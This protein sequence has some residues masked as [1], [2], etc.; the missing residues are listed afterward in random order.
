MN[1]LEPDSPTF[2]IAIARA[3]NL[4]E[5]ACDCGG[6]EASKKRTQELEGLVRRTLQRNQV[7][8]E[9]RERLIRE[10]A[11]T[12]QQLAISRQERRRLELLRSPSETYIMISGLCFAVFCM[13]YD[14]K[15]YISNSLQAYFY[16]NETNG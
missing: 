4:E 1:N 5:P 13:L 15:E 10:L 3:A 14:N 2:P 12:G 7:L 9:N 11:R 8:H 16:G 6:C